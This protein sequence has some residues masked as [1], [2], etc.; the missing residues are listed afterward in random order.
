MKNNRLGKNR[1]HRLFRGLSILLMM[2]LLFSPTSVSAEEKH[3]EKT[4]V[5]EAIETVEQT[6]EATET[7]DKNTEATDVEVK[8]AEE[9]TVRVGYV[10]A[11]NYEEGGE[12]EYKRGAGYEYLQKI[13]YLTGWKYEYVYGSFSECCTMLANGEIDLFGNVSYTPERAELFNFSTYP[14]GKDTYW[15]Y[16]GKNRQDLTDGDM[17]KLNGCRIGVTDGSYQEGLLEQ[18]LQSNRIEAEVVPCSGYDEMMPSMDAGQLDAIVAPDLA[19]G[20]DYQAVVSIGFSDFYFAVSKE[21]TDILEELNR[22]LYEIQ[23]G[24]ADYNSKLSSRYYYKAVSG[25]PFNEEEKK[26][27]SEHENTLRLGCYADNLPFCGEE[28][29]ELNGVINTVVDMLKTEYKINIQVQFFSSLQE[30]KQALRADEVDVIGPVISDYYLTEQDGFVLTDSIVDT[31]PVIIYKEDYQNSLQ[32]IAA[33]DTTLFGPDIIGVLYP[34]AEIYPCNTQEECLQAVSDGRAGSTLIP[35]SRINIL[36]ANPLMDGLSFAEMAKQTEVGL[37]ATKENR[38]AATI[39]NKGIEQSSDL[40]SGV[41][42]AQHSVADESISLTEFISKYAW[43]FISLA[44]AIIL[45]LG[46]L[47]YRLSVSRKQLVAAL[48]E[49]RNANSAN[50]AKTTFLNN[51]SHDIR[52]P[53]NAIIGFT[54]IA[55]KSDPEPEVRNCLEKVKQSS[56]YLLS[57]IN[58]VLDISRIESGNVKYDPEP[59][60]ITAVTDSVLNIANGFMINRVLKFEVHRDEP[61]TRY[62]LADEVRL[63]EILINIISNAVRFTHDGGTITFET[64]RMPGTDPQ[65]FVFCYRISDTGIG[66]SQEFTKHIFDEFSQENSG[67]RTQY[68]GTGLGMAITKHYVELMGGSITVDSV[69]GEGTTFTVELPL[70]LAEPIRKEEI[71]ETVSPEDLT[72]LHILM[73]EDNDLNAEIATMLLEEK[74]MQVTRAADGQEAVE[75]FESHPAGTFQVILMDIMMPQMNGYEAT[76]A[77]RHLEN[78]PDGYTIPI[79][80]L[81]A[82]AFAEDVE[83]AMDAGMNAHLAKPIVIDTV[84]KVIAE[85]LAS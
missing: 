53:M 15:L 11:L 84:V 80:A 58:D 55:L 20:Y 38:R 2:V 57:L 8:Q 32:V 72:G 31:T 82:N 61:E 13:S 65:H 30:M 73:A 7:A 52:T 74:G 23:T 10:N 59:V 27:L 81:T 85:T 50:V 46:T 39:F 19:T 62:V 60:D 1:K 54:D 49:V 41:V 28:N 14:Q 71:H 70:E 22:A 36:N 63:R 34:D 17:N 79:I 43:I 29:G 9:K 78:R 18:W 51:M 40:L 5:V 45:I 76:K 16:V 67:A 24:E 26:W 6:T 56:D 42:L 77:I 21:R 3:I 25:L 47:L 69:K 37:L 75:I 64:F 35:S 48:D 66:M 44:C 33:S 4:E 12:G 83:A 68:Q